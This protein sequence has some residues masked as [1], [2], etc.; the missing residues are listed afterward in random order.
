MI[1]IGGASI[2]SAFQL[3]PY[4]YPLP[5]SNHHG[6]PYMRLSVSSPNHDKTAPMIGTSRSCR[7]LLAGAADFESIA[8]RATTAP[9]QESAA[10]AQD[11]QSWL[12]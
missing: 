6:S 4:E 1:A 11:E 3:A 10:L 2:V 5:H 7:S 12:I 8:N 9:L